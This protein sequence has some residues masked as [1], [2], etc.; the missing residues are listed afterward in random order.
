[1]T[2]VGFYSHS[3]LIILPDYLKTG[4]FNNNLFTAYFETSPSLKLK[5]LVYSYIL[6]YTLFHTLFPS[7][8]LFLSLSLLQLHK[9]FN[10]TQSNIKTMSAFN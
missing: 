7:L 8:C 9:L 5:K 4:K 1:M 10:R 3:F 2:N 6:S